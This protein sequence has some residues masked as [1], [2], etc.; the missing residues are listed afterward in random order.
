V[1]D[2]NANFIGTKL[3]RTKTRVDTELLTV[4]RKANGNNF[5]RRNCILAIS[6][7]SRFSSLFDLGEI[8]NLNYLLVSSQ[9]ISLRITVARSEFSVRVLFVR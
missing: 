6:E 2:L 7:Q 1:P 3:A 4:Q 8:L 9:T 5:F